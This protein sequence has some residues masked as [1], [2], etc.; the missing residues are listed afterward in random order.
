M[1]KIKGE[2]WQ[3]TSSWT[4]WCMPVGQP[5]NIYFGQ[6]K[7]LYQ[8][9]YSLKQVTHVST[10]PLWIQTLN[11]LIMKKLFSGRGGGGGTAPG[12]AYFLTKSIRGK[13]N[14]QLV[15]LIVNAPFERIHSNIHIFMNHIALTCYLYTQ[16]S[17]VVNKASS[18]FVMSV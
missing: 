14:Y 6:I 4:E 10:Y 11:K 1:C 7:Y 9:L 8:I 12:F 17:F 13:V 15:W 2:P 3:P 18:Y 16:T 5:Q